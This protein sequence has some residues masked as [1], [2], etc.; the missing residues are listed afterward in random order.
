MSAHSILAPSSFARI[1]QCPGSLTMEAGFPEG[2][3][4]RTEALEGEAAHWAMAEMLEGRLVNIGDTAANGVVLTQEMVEGAD[5]IYDDVCREL[6]PYGLRPSDGATEVSVDIKSVHPLCFGTPDYRIWI[7]ARAPER[8]HP[9]LLLW[10]FKF[11]HRLVEA[12]MN[13]Q[14]ILYVIGVLQQASAAD[15]YV[16]V[17]VRIVQPRAHHAQGP[18][19]SWS[20]KGSDMRPRLVEAIEAANAALGPGPVTR[21]GPECRDCRARHACPSLQRAAMDACDVAGR[22]QP[23]ELTPHALGVELRMLKRAESMLKARIGGLEEQAAATIRRGQLVPGWGV[24]HGNGRLKWTVPDAQV[25]AMGKMLGVDVA[26]PPEAITPLQAIDKG[27][28]DVLV[29]GI[30]QRLPGAATL[31]EDDGS[32]ARRVFGRQA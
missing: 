24:A 11:G 30:S 15:L 32:A 2:D 25:I 29:G 7:P 27:L 26:K 22:A 10:D 28:T 9:K 5:M 4:S 16:D 23:L 1:V 12:Y 20:F 3:E 14:L 31:V 18:I 21:I 19:R 17:E 6:A 13:W 8:V